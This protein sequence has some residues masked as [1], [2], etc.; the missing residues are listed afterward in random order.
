MDLYIDELDITVQAFLLEN[1]PP[2]LSIGK[3][4]RVHGFVYVQS[5]SQEPILYDSKFTLATQLNTKNDVPLM[6]PEL[7][8]DPLTK[9]PVNSPREGYNAKTAHNE[10]H[11]IAEANQHGPKEIAVPKLELN[12]IDAGVNLD[13]HAE[14]ILPLQN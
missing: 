13:Q 1:S 4:C 9:T 12:K 7:T 11:T 6:L 8:N 2:L 5:G 14:I 3:L 10:I